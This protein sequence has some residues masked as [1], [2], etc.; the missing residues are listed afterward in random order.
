MEQ[1]PRTAERLLQVLRE[2]GESSVTEL[3]RRTGL[4]KATA[5]RL[6]KLLREAG[7]IEETGDDFRVHSAG[8]AGR[9]LRIKPDT[10][11]YLGLHIGARFVTA[12]VTDAAKRVLGWVQDPVPPIGVTPDSV[13]ALTCEAADRALLAAGCVSGSLS[14][15]ALAVAGPVDPRTG[16]IAN[17]V[18]L[19]ALRDVDPRPIL[20]AHL[21]QPVVMEND[22]ACALLAELLWGDVTVHDSAVLLRIGAGIGGAV[23]QQGNLVHGNSGRAGSFGHISYRPDGIPCRCGSRGCYERYLNAQDVLSHVG[24]PRGLH[25]LEDIAVRAQTDP[26]VAAELAA[27]GEIL[28]HLAMVV[29]RTIDPGRILVGGDMTAL[30]PIF[31]ETASKTLKTLNAAA[32]G[33]ELATSGCL[34]NPA[35]E[36]DEPALGAVGLLLKGRSG[37][38]V[39]I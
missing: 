19:P 18:P 23:L 29:S 36:R 8:R 33:L 31:L 30:G 32:P 13:L 34:L 21:G 9:S 4:G 20:A 22:A 16:A 25:R 7:L 24:A 5:S 10:A 15:V 39:R 2:D 11:L 35:N 38:G 14:G 1:I 27:R 28:G 3:A 12:V 37:A 17:S 26:A 6:V